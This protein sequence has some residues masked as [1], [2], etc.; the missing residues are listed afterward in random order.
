MVGCDAPPRESTPGVPTAPSLSGE[1]ENAPE[2]YR[3]KFSTT[4]GDFVVAVYERWAPRAAE[5]FRELIEEQFYDQCKFFRAVEG[6]MVQFGI[7]GDPSV[8]AKW[9]ERRMPDDPVVQSNTRGTITFATSGPDSR[10]TQV[11]INFGDNSR[12]DGMGFAPFGRVVEGMDVVDSLHKGYGEEPSAAQ[13]QIQMEGNAFLE[14]AFPMLDG[15][16]TARIME[17]RSVPPTA[18]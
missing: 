17:P 4:K 14:K 7:S 5:R 10:T 13:Q 16:L 12:L 9:R 6:F 1:L 8:S 11:F 3:V 18:E 2:S 15:I